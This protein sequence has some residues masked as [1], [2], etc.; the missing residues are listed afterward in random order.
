MTQG[1]SAHKPTVQLLDRGL[2]KWSAASP[3]ISCT[4]VNLSLPASWAAGTGLNAAA[5]RNCAATP[6]SS[7]SHI[8]S[9]HGINK[10]AKEKCS[11]LNRV[12]FI[13]DLFTRQ[14]DGSWSPILSKENILNS[15]HVLTTR[16]N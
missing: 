13:G 3:Q 4:S 6:V 2:F 8:N 11:F 5:L 16:S 9:N 15:A 14:F 12:D 10:P 1:V 7:R